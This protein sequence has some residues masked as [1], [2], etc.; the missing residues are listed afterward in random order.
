[1]TEYYFFGKM[2][3]NEWNVDFCEEFD[4]EFSD[5][6]DSVQDKILSYAVALK[7]TGPLLGRP[8]VDT[9]EAS[10]HSNMKELRF[11]A[12]N[13]VWR[14]AFAFDL[15]RNAILLIAG[16]KRGKDQKKFYKGLIKKADSRFDRHLQK[17][18]KKG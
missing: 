9:L 3:M 6:P 7:Q 4:S 12:D 11:S 1:M 17:E 8:M 5:L 2:N 15:S 10:K 14:V 18:V 16:D 13:G